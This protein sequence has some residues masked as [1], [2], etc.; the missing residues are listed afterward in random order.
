[1]I[2]HS[3]PKEDI[4]RKINETLV[5]L[6]EEETGSGNYHLLFGARE[7]IKYL[8]KHIESLSKCERVTSSEMSSLLTKSS[9]LVKYWNAA[10]YKPYPNLWVMGKDE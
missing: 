2:T 5:T 6:T 1:M 10:E 8:R 3:N 9:E 7:E 4:L